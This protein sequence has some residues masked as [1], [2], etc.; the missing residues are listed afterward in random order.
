MDFVEYNWYYFWGNQ[1]GGTIASFLLY[2]A[3]MRLK[4]HQQ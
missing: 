3:K 2:L 4:N 1:S